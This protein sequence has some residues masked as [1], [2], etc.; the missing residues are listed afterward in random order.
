[1]SALPSFSAIL[2]VMSPPFTVPKVFV[3]YVEITVLWVVTSCTCSFVDKSL[4]FGGLEVAQLIVAL[5]YKP[6]SRWF[7]SYGFTVIFYWLNPSRRTVALGSTEPVTEMNARNI[8]WGVK[9]AGPQGWQ[10]LQLHVP[11]VWKSGILNF[12]EPSVSVQT[13]KFRKTTISFVMSVRP[14]AWDI[15]APTGRIFVKFYIW[16]CLRKS[17][18]KNSSFTKIGQ[19]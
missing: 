7:Y 15:F 3:L 2:S 19:E 5:R 18:E 17:V 10:P 8:S 4:H 14:S 6:K 1:M 9:A 13:C 16:V 11:T 12:L